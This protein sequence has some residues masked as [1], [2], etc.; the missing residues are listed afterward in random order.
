MLFRSDEIRFI[1]YGSSE[2]Y[3][4]TNY[5]I[6]VPKD[7]D[8]KYPYIA[9]ATLCYFPECSRSQGVDYTNRE[10]SLQFGRINN[11]GKINDINQNL[12]DDSEN[13]T[14]ERQSRKEFRKWDNTKFISRIVKNNKSMKSYDERLWG[15]SITSKERLNPQMRNSLKFGV[16]ITLK[17]LNAINRI[18]EFIKACTL[19]GWIVN[20]IT[21]QNQINIYNTSNEDIH[22]E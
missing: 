14:D 20:Q 11:K 19:R 3:R 7:K 22:F 13:R 21:I 1:L 6:P 8:N 4:T 10:L 15:I 12:Q 18:D 5:A 17:E 9:R 2:S 16:V